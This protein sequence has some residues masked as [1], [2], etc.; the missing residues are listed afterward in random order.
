[1]LRT[2]SQP[3]PLAPWAPCPDPPSSPSPCSTPA[4]AASPCCTSC[5]SRCPP[6]TTCTSATRRAFPTA[7]AAP[8]ELQAFAVEIAEHLL[9][10]GRQAARRRLQLGQRRGAGR[11]RGA[12]W[13]RT[14]RDDRRDRRAR[15]RPPSS[16]S[17]ASHSGRIGLLATPATVA[18]GAYERDR[19]RRRPA[20]APGERG[21][22]GPGADHRGA[23]SR[24]TSTSWRPCA[25]YC[26]PLRARR[27]RHGDPRLHPLPADRADAPAD[28]RPRA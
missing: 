10:V 24:S 3:R 22:P 5:S 2:R 23:A 27:G 8:T 12:T 11:A 7:T 17:P 25:S 14:G 9:D 18:S 4:S 6:R 1:M 13:P 20:R 15:A 26:A 16:R 28:A 21:L 19:A